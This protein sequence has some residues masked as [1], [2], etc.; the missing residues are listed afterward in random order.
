MEQKQGIGIGQST[1][2]DVNQFC[3][4]VKLVLTPSE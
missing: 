4:D 2:I 1:R 3:G